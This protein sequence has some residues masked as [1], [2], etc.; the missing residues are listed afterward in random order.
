[1]GVKIRGGS[2][3]EPEHRPNLR[4]GL[5]PMATNSCAHLGRQEAH[6]HGS[7]LGRFLEPR[8]RRHVNSPGICCV[9]MTL[10]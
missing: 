5:K 3:F 8:K 2:V 1:M 10:Y 9:R 4:H 6:Y 7:D